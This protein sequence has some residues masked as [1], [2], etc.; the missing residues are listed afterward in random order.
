ML[1]VRI[2]VAVVVTVAEPFELVDEF[3]AVEF[4]P[5]VVDVVAVLADAGL[6][7]QAADMAV[8]LVVVV[9]FVMDPKVVAVVV[10]VAQSVEPVDD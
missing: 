7:L 2:V 1:D 6:D 8:E 10:A 5:K 9:E 3:V 4:E